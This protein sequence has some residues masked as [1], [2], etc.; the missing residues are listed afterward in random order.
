MKGLMLF[1]LIAFVVA[2]TRD[3]FIK[4]LKTY[5]KAIN[6]QTDYKGLEACIRDPTTN[7]IMTKISVDYIR[8][9]TEEGITIGSKYLKSI[10]TDLVTMLK[11][12]Y[13]DFDKL[14]QLGELLKN[15]TEQQVVEKIKLRSEESFHLATS[16][17]AG[18]CDNEY[19]KAG[20]NVGKLVKI[21]FIPT[22]LGDSM[23]NFI[24]GFTEGI[25]E[26]KSPTV[27]LT[28]AKDNDNLFELLKTALNDIYL[29]DTKNMTKG[30]TVI[31]DESK[32]L[33]LTLQDCLWRYERIKELDS[34]LRNTTPQKMVSIINREQLLF[35]K[36]LVDAIE[37]FR[38]K[39]YKG[40]GK[41]FG[42]MH[43]LLF[44]IANH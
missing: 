17:Y 15:T 40:A 7:I 44:F 4:Y 29:G 25:K 21:V 32:K 34:K 38:I 2:S 39:D 33:I 18:L 19:E 13:K 42:A 22:P 28:C 26:P 37:K 41:V 43:I 31:L 5:L 16:A 6:E 24:T 20:T 36:L 30:C 27:L 11:P 10:T 9:M 3:D 23:K 35:L 1:M 8:K 14:K 12:C